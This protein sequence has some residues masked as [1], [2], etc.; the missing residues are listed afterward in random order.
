M[1]DV[2]WRRMC[3]VWLGFWRA[4]REGEREGG[5]VHFCT[6][7]VWEGGK[8]AEWEG[9]REGGRDR[10]TEGGREGGREGGELVSNTELWRGRG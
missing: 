7:W 1:E 2:I 9:E 5:S 10:G 6:L 8:E 4:R 3:F